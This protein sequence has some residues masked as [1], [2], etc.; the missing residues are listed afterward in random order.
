MNARVVFL[1]RFLVLVTVFF[2]IWNLISDRFLGLVISVGGVVIW[3]L[4]LFSDVR[5]SPE[6]F[7]IAGGF[8]SI[9]L[10][11]ALVLA[12]SGVSWKRRARLVLLGSVVLFF[13]QVL[14]FD[15]QLLFYGLRRPLVSFYAIV[16]RIGLPLLMWF[17]S[18]R[19]VVLPGVPAEKKPVKKKRK[20]KTVKKRAGSK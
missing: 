15:L 7:D 2:S 4:R 9:P 5:F 13:F 18:V 16:G 12:T 20:V 10:F 14:V 6:P 3:F 1:A 8:S 19:E 11:A 17:V